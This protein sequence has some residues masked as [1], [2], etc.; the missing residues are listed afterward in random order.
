MAQQLYRSALDIDLL[1]KNDGVEYFLKV[2]KKVYIRD[3]PRVFMW[4]FTNFLKC[5]RR[6]DD[7]LAWLHKYD[8]EFTRL[9]DAWRD[10]TP[11]DIDHN[12]MSH[13]VRGVVNGYVNNLLADERPE[14][15]QERIA[16]YNVHAHE[17]HLS[18]LPF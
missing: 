11:P 17:V 18:K 8:L 14:L 7:I 6:G 10:L 12:D 4:R 16:L 1:C 13:T 3:A 15:M 2:L 9:R 5:R